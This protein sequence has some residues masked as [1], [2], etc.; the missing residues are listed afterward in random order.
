MSFTRSQIKLATQD[1]YAEALNSLD[2]QKVINEMLIVVFD[3]EPQDTDFYVFPYLGMLRF[4]DE[5]SDEDFSKIMKKKL[6]RKFYSTHLKPNTKYRY[7]IGYL[8]VPHGYSEELHGKHSFERILDEDGLIGHYVAFILDNKT[9]E[10]WVVDSLSKNPLTDSN[11]GIEN[12]LQYLYPNYTQ[13]SYDICSGCG[14]YEPLYDEVMDEQNIF[15][16]TWTLYYIFTILVGVKKGE[17]LE[18]IFVYFENSCGTEKANLILIKNFARYVW[19][20]YVWQE[21]MPELP[22]EFMYIWNPR[23]RKSESIGISYKDYF[24]D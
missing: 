10:V 24:E 6:K 12:F 21:G 11:I 4:G 1:V 5:S 7:N 14:S 19:D 13:R 22:E 23:T 2:F 3:L 18:N 20:E 8:S 9:K 16:H 15:C 17:S